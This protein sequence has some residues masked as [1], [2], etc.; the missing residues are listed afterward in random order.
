MVLLILAFI[1]Q[2]E[3]FL[4][5]FSKILSFADLLRLFRSRFRKESTPTPTSQTTQPAVAQTAVIKEENKMKKIVSIEG[6]MCDHCSGRVEKALNAIP[7]VTASV[8]LKGKCAT[9]ECTAEV[10]DE[11]LKAAV[12]D[13]G[14]EVTGIR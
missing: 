5:S 2:R 4:H 3:L 10:T 1:C 12:T 13:A 14:Y 9:V 7:G 8:D 11:Q 6:M